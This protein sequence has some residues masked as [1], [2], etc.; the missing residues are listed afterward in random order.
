MMDWDLQPQARGYK[1]PQSWARP[2]RDLSGTLPA[3][4]LWSY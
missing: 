4:A 2:G 1:S 3:A